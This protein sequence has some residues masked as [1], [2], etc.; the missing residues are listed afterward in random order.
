MKAN[1]FWE[2]KK[3]MDRDNKRKENI[4][5]I[6][7]ENGE[8]ETDTEKIKEIFKNFYTELQT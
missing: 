7:N 4:T 1:I 8:I 3:R 6:K 5:A 2:F